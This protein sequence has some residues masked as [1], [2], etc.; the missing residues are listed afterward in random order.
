[1]TT[2]HFFDCEVGN[3]VPASRHAVEQVLA[4]PVDYDDGRSEFVWIRL[5][6][7][8]LILGVF[9]VGDTY[10]HASELAEADFADP[11]KRVLPV[12]A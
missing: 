12:Y 9:P 4:A 11:D 10:V 7:G 2:V 6:G 1:M 5:D 3:Y 8:D